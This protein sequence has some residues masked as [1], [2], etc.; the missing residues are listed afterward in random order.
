LKTAQSINQTRSGEMLLLYI[1]SNSLVTCC[2][3][4]KRCSDTY[5]LFG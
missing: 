4:K 3:W 1:N 2:Y 5:T